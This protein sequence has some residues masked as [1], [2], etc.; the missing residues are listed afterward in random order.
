MTREPSET[1]APNRVVQSFAAF[2]A[3]PQ[4]QMLRGAV[5]EDVAVYYPGAAEAQR[6]PEAYMAAVQRY[7][8]AVPDLRLE[9]VEYAHNGDDTFVRWLAR[10][11]GK[12]GRFELT[13]VDRIRVRDGL[14]VENRIFYDSAEFARLS[15]GRGVPG[16]PA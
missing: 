4:P 6:G 13:G 5:G 14:V 7:L 10:G 12:H 3:N 1:Q 8:D 15:G 11:T 2:W 16:L 9:V